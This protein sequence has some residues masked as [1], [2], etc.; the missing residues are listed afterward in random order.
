MAI[1]KSKRRQSSNEKYVDALQEKF[2]KLAVIR[3]DLGYK[4]D[5]NNQVDVTLEDVKRDLNTLS[6]NNRNNSAY[7]NLAGYIFKIEYG[8]DKGPHVHALFFFDGNKVQNDKFK[9]DQIGQNWKKIT[10]GRGC[11]HNCNRNNYKENATGM[12]DYRDI[13]KRRNLDKAMEYFSKEEQ[14]IDALKENGKDRSIR[15]GTIPKEKSTRGRP[16]NQ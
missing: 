1:S 14:S 2:S 10:K 9:A 15:R 4:K 8:V 13:E 6:N 11:Y 7:D 16:R 5:E 12:L 3:N